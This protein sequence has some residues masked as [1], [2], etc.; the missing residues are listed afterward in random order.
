MFVLHPCTS[1][2][3]TGSA[4]CS[5]LLSDVPQD[6][7]GGQ[8]TRQG[9]GGEEAALHGNE[10]VNPDW[11]KTLLSLAVFERLRVV[12]KTRGASH[13]EQNSSHTLWLCL[14]VL[15]VSPAVFGR[16]FVPLRSSIFEAFFT[17]SG[18]R[19]S[20]LRCDP[21]VDLQDCLQTPVCAKEMQP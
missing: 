8:Q 7:R 20:E 19:S 9:H 15:S 5:A 21:T 18:R 13:V 1:T 16:H 4:A 3:W 6:D 12:Q 2:C 11:E 10:W 14:N 17:L